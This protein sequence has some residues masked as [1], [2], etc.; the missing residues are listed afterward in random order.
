[1]QIRAKDHS[2]RGSRQRERRADAGHT[3]QRREQACG[4]LRF[5]LLGQTG[6]GTQQRTPGVSV[7]IFSLRERGQPML[8][9]D[10]RCDAGERFVHRGHA[11][12]RL[13]VG[14]HGPRIGSGH[15]SLGRLHTPMVG[16][17]G[18][19]YGGAQPAAA[20]ARPSVGDCLNV[21]APDGP[22][23]SDGRAKNVLAR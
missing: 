20:P 10:I 23:F 9:P 7:P 3:R 2:F 17:G 6:F 8:E 15:R 18:G 13:P 5:T 21:G 19:R 16:M 22:H 11:N 4:E 1:M 12:F 14:A